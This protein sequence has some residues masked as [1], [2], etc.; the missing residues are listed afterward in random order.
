MC[1]SS[2][3]LQRCIF[4]ML[5]AISSISRA[6]WTLWL[7]RQDQMFWCWRQHQLLQE[8]SAQEVSWA[9][10]KAQPT[11]SWDVT[12]MLAR[13]PVPYCSP[14]LISKGRWLI[15]NPQQRVNQKTVTKFLKGCIKSFGAPSLSGHIC[16]NCPWEASNAAVSNAGAT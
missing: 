13:P 10:R 9:P 4:H 3:V 1:Y 14:A 6:A 16:C 15:H 2:T 12:N 11:K 8:E 7:W 5:C